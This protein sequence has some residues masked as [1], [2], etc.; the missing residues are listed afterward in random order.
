MVLRQR[1]GRRRG[2]CSL[3]SHDADLN[4]PTVQ[5]MKQG[6]LASIKLEESNEHSFNVLDLIWDRGD[7]RAG[8]RI[9]LS[10]MILALQQMMGLCFLSRMLSLYCR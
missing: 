3:S 1:E 9:R 5:N 7:L 10:F 4:D 6:I 2:R 8:R